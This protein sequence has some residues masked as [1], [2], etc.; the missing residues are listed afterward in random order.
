MTKSD[1]QTAIISPFVLVPETVKLTGC[2]RS[3]ILKYTKTGQ[4]P[5]AVRLLG[6]RIAFV[7]ADVEQWIDARLASNKEAV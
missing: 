4:F 3:T 6:D 7:R 5:K 1:S 2:P